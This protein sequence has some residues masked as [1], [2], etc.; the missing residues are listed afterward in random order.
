MIYAIQCGE[1]GPI[2]FGKAKNAK[3]RLDAMKTGCPFELRLLTASG[4]HESNERLIHW[5]LRDYRLRGEWFSP[6][7]KVQHVANRLAGNKFYEL[8][9]DIAFERAHFGQR[10]KA[11]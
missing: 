11:P 1:S 10:W 9:R 4:W 3:A 5:Y 8:M 7:P 6:V 2:K